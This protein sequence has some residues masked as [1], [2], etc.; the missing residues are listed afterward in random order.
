MPDAIL[1]WNEVA[2]EANRISHTRE[3]KEQAGPPLSA[4]AL[5]IVHLAMYD[6]YSAIDS[7]AR[8]PAGGGPYLTGLPA[9]PTGAT[10][11]AAA[12][13]AAYITLS[14]LF[15][16]Q[17]ATFDI[18]LGQG[19]DPRDPGHDFGVE[20]GMALLQD[21]RRDP[22]ASAGGWVPSLERCHHRPD[23]DNPAQGFHAPFYGARSRGFA[24]SA[25]H[26][27]D[28][29]PCDTDDYRRALVQVR[30]LGIV[31]ELAGTLPDQLPINGMNVPVTKRVT[32]QTL[33]GIFWAYDGAIG[34]G[35]PPRFYNQIIR[36]V[37]AVRNNS[38]AQNAALFA[39]VNAALADA[40]ILAWDYKYQYDL[41]R[42]VVGIREHDASMGPGTKTAATSISELTDT[43]WLPLGAP[44][45]N[46]MNPTFGMQTAGSYPCN[47]AVTGHMKN[48]TPNFPAYPSGH[49]TFGAA[50]FHI[51]RL[52][53]Q[54]GGTLKKKDLR[55]DDLLKGLR[56]VSEELNGVNQDNRGTVRPRHLRKYDDGLWGMILENGLSR[57]YLGVH[58]VFDAFP[59][60]A[61]GNHDFYGEVGGVP[62]GLA[63]AEDIATRGLVKSPV[64]PRP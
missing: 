41:W 54:V 40:G 38:E 1:F 59:V 12:A 22:D 33:A 8:F 16:S 51:T 28:V 45:T 50:A 27:L 11:A 14:E 19:G 17:Q 46:S 62:L 24:I 34:L 15:P 9:P 3:P 26:R 49:A 47:H 10:A 5:A 6:A 20:V 36:R 13:G 30:G 55:R 42:P 7:T 18:A 58:W 25:R 29:P 4:R 21:R 31:P 52:F 63:I 60:D 39:L 53:Y 2:L 23:P 32:D 48:F 57:V 61:K 64:G 35:T 56:F 37:A 43:A 44:A